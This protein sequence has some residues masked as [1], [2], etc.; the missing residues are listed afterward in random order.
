MIVTSPLVQTESGVIARVIVAC[1][2]A[3]CCESKASIGEAISPSSFAWGSG[4]TVALRTHGGKWA[5][6]D[7]L[8]VPIPSCPLDSSGFILLFPTTSPFKLCILFI[9]VRLEEARKESE[10]PVSCYVSSSE[11]KRNGAGC[12]IG[13]A[14]YLRSWC[15]PRCV[16]CRHASTARKE[17]EQDSLEEGA[18]STPAPS[19][20]RRRRLGATASD[21]QTQR[22]KQM[23]A[24]L[25]FLVPSPRSS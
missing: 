17:E 7:A 1:R 3:A 16:C 11:K 15:F 18:Q 4:E 22:R 24:P 5:Q 6:V 19:E 2:R 25:P 9:P 12:R 14:M 8:H 21:H 13:K 10:G 23:Q 20:C